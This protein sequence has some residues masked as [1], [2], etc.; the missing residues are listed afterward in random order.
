MYFFSPISIAKLE[1]SSNVL[2]AGCAK[3]VDTT[4][5]EL[6]VRD[7]VLKLQKPY[8]SSQKHRP[9][10]VVQYGTYTVAHYLST[11]ANPYDSLLTGDISRCRTAVNEGRNQCLTL[12][13][14]YWNPNLQKSRKISQH[15]QH[16][17][18]RRFCCPFPTFCFSTYSTAA[19]RRP[20]VRRVLPNKTC[21]S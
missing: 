10:H 9:L 6:G 13:C 21:I 12:L 4:T 11:S 18:I 5:I 16:L 1:V 3:G 14:C 7:F 20:H 15:H 17:H 19:M 2:V 8:C